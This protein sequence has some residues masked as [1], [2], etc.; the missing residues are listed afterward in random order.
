M[1]GFLEEDEPQTLANGSNTIELEDE[2][3]AKDENVKAKAVAPDAIVSF[4][5]QS[6]YP[7]YL[8]KF[9]F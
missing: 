5:A 9:L 2:E 1:S 7:I 8:F 3:E 4:D 6:I